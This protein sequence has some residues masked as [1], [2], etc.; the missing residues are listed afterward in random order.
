MKT[1]KRLKTNHVTVT[2]GATYFHANPSNKDADY[3]GSQIF[4]PRFTY[5]KFH[6]KNSSLYNQHTVRICN[7]HSTSLNFMS[8]QADS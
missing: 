3:K 4:K 7:L 1:T 2:F 8:K 6:L 5:I